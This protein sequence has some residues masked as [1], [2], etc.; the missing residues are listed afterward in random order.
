M[1]FTK[2]INKYLKIRL[3]NFDSTKTKRMA[4]IKICKTHS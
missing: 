1:T 2:L 3:K 4:A